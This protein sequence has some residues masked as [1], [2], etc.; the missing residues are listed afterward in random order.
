MDRLR[1]RHAALRDRHREV[2]VERERQRAWS[3]EQRAIRK[4]RAYVDASL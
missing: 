3:D 2:L 1:R 4:A